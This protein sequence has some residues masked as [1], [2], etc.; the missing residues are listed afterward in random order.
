MNLAFYESLD[1]IPL[2]VAVT[3]EFVGPLGVAVAGSRRASTCSGWRSR[4]PASC[5][6]PTS[7]RRDLDP[8]GVALA[9]LAGAL[10]GGVHPAGGAG[11]AAF[12]GRRRLALAMVAGAV[13][14]RCPV[15]RRATAARSCCRRRCWPSGW[16][17][18]CCRRRSPTRSSSR[19]CGGCRGR[20]RRADEPRAGGGRARRLPGAGRGPRRARARRDRA[21][22]GG[23]R[24][25]GARA[26]VPPGMP[27]VR[28]PGTASGCVRA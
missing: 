24:R 14:A 7:A 1:R 5:C 10:L 12:A 2:G 9:L 11:G 28:G 21:G 20:V 16:R 15:G 23:Q 22:G 27:E 19:R 6:C 18:R 8:T 26:N 25:S 17:W 13:H 4:R 3:F